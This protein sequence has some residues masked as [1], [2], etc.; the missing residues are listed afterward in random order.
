MSRKLDYSATDFL[1]KGLMNEIC[2]NAKQSIVE[3]ID[4]KVVI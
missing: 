2:L 3:A 4:A 1:A